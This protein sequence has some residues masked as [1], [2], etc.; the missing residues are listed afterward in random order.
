[1]SKFTD[2]LWTDLVREHGAT[3][4]HDDG[5]EPGRAR[6][7]RRRVLAGSTLVAS[8]RYA[9]RLDVTRRASPPNWNMVSETIGKPL[10]ELRD[11]VSQELLKRDK[12][13]AALVPLD[14]EPVPPEYQEQVKQYYEKLGSGK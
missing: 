8:Q 11:K 9:V 6:R 5:P 14:R 13:Q 3:L 10:A 2:R 1:M 4:A 12:A 7:P